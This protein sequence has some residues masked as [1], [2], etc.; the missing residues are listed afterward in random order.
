VQPGS[1][2]WGSRL[3]PDLQIAYPIVCNRATNGPANG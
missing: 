2:K 3:D 1:K